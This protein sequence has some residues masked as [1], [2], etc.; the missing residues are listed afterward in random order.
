VGGGVMSLSQDENFRIMDQLVFLNCREWI[1]FSP[2][3]DSFRFIWSTKHMLQNFLTPPI[4]NSIQSLFLH[5]LKLKTSCSGK[6]NTN[7]TTVDFQ[8]SLFFSTEI[9]FQ[10]DIQ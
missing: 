2:T 4:T 7:K 10:I 8:Q 5:T 6:K 9:E 3:S 1:P